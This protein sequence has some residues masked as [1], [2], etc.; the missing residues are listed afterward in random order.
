M[1]NLIFSDRVKNVFSS[2]NTDY[3]SMNNLMQDLAL[4]RE[5]YDAENDKI[6]SKSEANA[7]ILDFSRKVLG[8]TDIND[9]KQVRRALRDN[10]REW[11]DI[12][13]DTVDRTIT[14]GLQESD[15]FN[16]LVES[17]TI[18]YHDR[19]D[20]YIEDDSV[21]SVAKA[22]T[23]HHDHILQRL[24]AGQTISIPTE[25]YVVK[26]GADINKYIT[27]QVDWNKLIE[28]ITAAFVNEIQ[29]EVYAEVTSAASKLPV[30]GTEYVN[31]GA[32]SASTKD[33]FDAI[34]DNVSAANNGAEVVIMGTK[35]GLSKVS[36]LANTSW[37]ADAQKNSMMNS[38]NIG[39][40][41][42]TKLVPIP[43]RFV[44]K[45]PTGTKQFDPNVLMIL[46]VIGDA[47]KFVKFVDEGDTEIVEKLERGEYTSDIQTYEVQRRFGVGTVIARQF[48]QWTITA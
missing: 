25:L 26:V 42:G 39:I 34:I 1:K 46:P 33:A 44:G 4:G 35:A 11:L 3:D 5:I 8:I 29:T 32:L 24:S 45:Q 31:T 27:G 40:Y 6:I 43:T 41:E 15:W 12:I 30:T 23:S 38:G 7:K 13:E 16:E 48:G 36:A 18:G 17:K 10:S 20:F 14:V 21:L 19:Q 2:L 37:G 22:G 9:A 28:A 47:G